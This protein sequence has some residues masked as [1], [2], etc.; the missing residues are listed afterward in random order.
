MATSA[1]DKYNW[2]QLEIE[3]YLVIW[4]V[5]WE[6]KKESFTLNAAPFKQTS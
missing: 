5:I 6:D 3:S 1:V 4:E 2:F